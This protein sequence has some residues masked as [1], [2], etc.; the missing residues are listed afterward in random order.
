[1]PV[2]AKSAAIPEVPAALKSY[3][4]S[5][6]QSSSKKASDAVSKSQKAM[7]SLRDWS[8]RVKQALE[9]TP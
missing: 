2:A 1:L 5:A 6:S 9:Q 4:P 3:V 8:S 7:E